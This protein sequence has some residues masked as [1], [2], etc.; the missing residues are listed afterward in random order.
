MAVSPSPHPSPLRGE[1]VEC[2]SLRAGSD[3]ATRSARA[4]PRARVRADPYVPRGR[5][6]IVAR[7]EL[8]E[9][10]EWRMAFAGLRKDHRFYELVEDTLE[11]GFDHRYFVVRDA[12]GE[13]IAIQPS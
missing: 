10:P 5:V 9:L 6:D 7:R 12:N 4:W 13:I 2:G 8:E 3:H 1:E 11:Q